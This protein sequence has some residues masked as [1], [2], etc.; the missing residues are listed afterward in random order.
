MARVW[1]RREGGTRSHVDSGTEWACWYAVSI[2]VDRL[3]N[4]ATMT[5]ALDVMTDRN[6][7]VQVSRGQPSSEALI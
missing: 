4:S 1:T 5:I 3:C 6:D 2:V 7:S